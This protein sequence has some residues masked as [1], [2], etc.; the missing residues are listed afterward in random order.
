MP[1]PKLPPGQAMTGAQRA[2]KARDKKRRFKGETQYLADEAERQVALRADAKEKRNPTEQ[3]A[4]QDDANLRVS[5]YL[6][7]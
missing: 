7:V 3:R 1:R 4:F 6:L 2:Q 5:N